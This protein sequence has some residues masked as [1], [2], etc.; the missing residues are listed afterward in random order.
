MIH[1]AQAES[2]EVSQKISI[3]Q[4]AMTEREK[5]ELE[6]MTLHSSP[7]EKFRIDAHYYRRPQRAHDL[8]RAIFLI[9]Q[10]ADAGFVGGQALLGALYEAGELLPK[11]EQ[12]ARIWYQKAADQ[13][14][15]HAQYSL[16]QMDEKGE[17]G[18]QNIK[19]ALSLYE[20]AAQA[21]Y[22]KAQHHLAELYAAGEVVPKDMKRAL[23]WEQR[24]AEQ[25]LAEAEVDLGTM[26]FMDDGVPLD[27]REA[28]SWIEVAR[29]FNE[30]L[31]DSTLIGDVQR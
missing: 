5:E 19:K 9:T 8:D 20:Q 10:S 25:G 27:Y 1:C 12:K 22:A 15:E 23:L 2:T 16:A 24:A 11:D 6:E 26:Y 21:G 17:G 28:V 7:E 4:G 29:F 13:G 31:R 18:S 14:E 3:T 30:R